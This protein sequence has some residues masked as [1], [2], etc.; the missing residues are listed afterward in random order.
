MSF[1]VQRCPKRSK[2]CAYVIYKWPPRPINL[3]LQPID[4]ENAFVEQSVTLSG[5]GLKVGETKDQTTKNFKLV[6]FEVNPKEFC[7]EEVFG[8]EALKAAGIGLF[9]RQR[10]IPKGIDEYFDLI[11]S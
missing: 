8:D 7:E 6:T 3:P 10:Q 5:W 9:K 1:G 4:D 11:M 2:K